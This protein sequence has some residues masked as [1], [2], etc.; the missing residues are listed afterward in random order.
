VLQAQHFAGRWRLIHTTDRLCGVSIP[1]FD[2]VTGLLPPGEH[3][4]GWAEVRERFGWNLRRRRLLDGLQEGMEALGVAGCTRVW[5]NGSFVTAKDEP[6]DFDA[7]WSPVGV[8]RATLAEMV[9]EVLD[10]SNH[11]AAQKQL[12]GGE[13]LPNIVEGGS[14]KQFASFFQTDRDGTSKGIVVID[15]SKETWE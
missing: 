11:R 13:F 7:V 1:P 8:H 12:F 2:P 3:D 5:L 15:P 10:L 9:P 4:A 14:G 6:G